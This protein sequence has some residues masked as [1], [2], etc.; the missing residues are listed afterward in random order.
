MLKFQQILMDMPLFKGISA[1]DLE[2]MLQCLGAQSAC[3]QKNDAVFLEGA[4]VRSIGVVLSGKIQV[5]REDYYGNRNIVA[6]L[7]PGELFAETFACAAVQSVPVSVF[8]AE[9]SEIMLLD[10]KKILSPCPS[11]CGFHRLL[12]ENLLQVMARKN[13]FLSGKLD[14]LSRRTT[15]E[16]LMAYLS[17]EA[18]KAGQSD[19]V[20][21]FKRQELA[22]YLGVERSAMSAQLCRMRDEGILEFNRNHFRLL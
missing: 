10:C 1:E 3:Y 13:L 6:N 21:P 4:Q 15:R 14:L 20:I 16:K 12:I 22:D 7:G 19:F 5:V 18:K 2:P 9:K 17:G 11:S 8:A